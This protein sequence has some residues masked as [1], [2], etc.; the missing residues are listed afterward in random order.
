M[1]PGFFIYVFYAIDNSEQGKLDKLESQR[2]KDEG[3]FKKQETETR[4]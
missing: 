2:E 3:Q 4:W 1:L